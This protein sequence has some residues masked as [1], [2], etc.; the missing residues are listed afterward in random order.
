MVRSFII[1]ILAVVLA[2]SYFPARAAE[3]A[4]VFVPAVPFE[5]FPAREL[6][7]GT[8]VKAKIVR[9]NEFAWTFRTR[10]R[11]AAKEAP[12]F[13]GHYVI[14][15]WGC[16]IYC[17]SGALISLKTGNIYPLPTSEWGTVYDV[18]SNLLVVNPVYGDEDEIPDWLSTKYF[19]WTGKDWRLMLEVFPQ[20]PA[21]VS[22]PDVAPLPAPTPA[23]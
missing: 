14:A 23:H 13:G 5:Q 3:E 18:T 4:V 10:L 8:R 20:Q 7:I 15:E 12:N 9:E 19:L 21:T 17:Q 16:G 6:Q 1:A 2:A 22:L 11:E